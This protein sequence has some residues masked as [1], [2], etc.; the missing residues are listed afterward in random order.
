MKY[1]YLDGKIDSKKYTA[2]LAEVGSAEAE[3]RVIRSISER[4]DALSSAAAVGG[5]AVWLISETGI[6]R[7]IG[8]DIKLF[9]LAAV[10]FILSRAYVADWSGTPR[11]WLY[12]I[13][14]ADRLI[15]AVSL[16]SGDGAEFLKILLILGAMP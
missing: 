15:S 1:D 6:S 4:V 14:L 12:E 7:I 2:F 5:A 11:F 16:E 8:R 10:V 3:L 13:I 9:L